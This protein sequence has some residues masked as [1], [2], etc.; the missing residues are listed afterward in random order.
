MDSDGDGRGNVCDPCPYDNLYGGGW[1]PFYDSD[2]DGR[3][4]QCDNCPHDPI[5]VDSTDT[6]GDGVGDACDCPGVNP[7]PYALCETQADC[8][9]AGKCIFTMW[10]DHCSRLPDADGDGLFD[11]CDACPGNPNDG[12][13]GITANSNLDAE[14]RW[15]SSLAPVSDPCDVVAQMV[16]RPDAVPSEDEDALCIVPGGTQEPCIDNVR[17]TATRAVGSLTDA[18]A[19]FPPSPNLAPVGFRHC[20]CYFNG[21][22]LSR[23]DCINSV[24]QLK[25]NDY[26]LAGS[27]SNYQMVTVASVTGNFGTITYPSSPTA[28]YIQRRFTSEVSQDLHLHPSDGIAGSSWEWETW[29]IGAKET[30]TWKLKDDIDAGHVVGYGPDG[31]ETAAPN[32]SWSS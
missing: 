21:N 30:I 24:C 11:A 29:R 23:D 3:A 7:T 10:A 27:T 9:G 1:F 4:D 15:A 12:Q 5:P 17:F 16:L 8:A 22:L 2:G 13:F 20:D 32:V 26:P 18:V 31:D 6:D 14:E 25:F 19:T 28:P